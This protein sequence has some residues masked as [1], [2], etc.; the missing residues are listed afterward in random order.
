MYITNI[1]WDS[2]DTGLP[3]EIDIPREMDIDE[4]AEYLSSE[5]GWCC[6]SF[7]VEKGHTEKWL[8]KQA[9]HILNLI[10]SKIMAS[11]DKMES[12]I[13]VSLDEFIKSYSDEEKKNLQRLCKKTFAKQFGIRDIIS[14][15]KMA[16]S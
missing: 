9:S 13:K 7:V 15:I 2:K 11:I 10:S 3:K 5:T 6:N 12:D 16:C 8:K 4:I 1:D 14:N